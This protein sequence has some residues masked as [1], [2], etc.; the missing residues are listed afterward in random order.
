MLTILDNRHFMNY[1]FINGKFLIV[2]NQNEDNKIN[3]EPQNKMTRKRFFRMR[4]CLVNK[5]TFI[6]K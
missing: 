6:F 2:N 4:G 5:K 3:I 1:S